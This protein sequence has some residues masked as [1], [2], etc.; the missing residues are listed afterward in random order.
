MFRVRLE[1][2]TV[3]DTTLVTRQVRLMVAG[4]RFGWGWSYSHPLRVEMPGLSQPI[5][6]HDHVLYLK[7]IAAMTTV[8][9]SLRR[10][11]S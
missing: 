7:L 6:I 2:K 4:S 9:I 11:R 5:K 1:R 10:S 8:A 3:G